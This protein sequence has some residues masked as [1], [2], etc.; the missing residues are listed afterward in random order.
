MFNAKT[1][2]TRAFKNI[3]NALKLL[4]EG[5]FKVTADRILLSEMDLTKTALVELELPDE[6]FDEFH[7][8]QD[9]SFRIDLDELRKVAKRITSND[10]IKLSFDDKSNQLLI[11]LENKVT[12]T[13]KIASQES[14]TVEL[15]TPQVQFKAEIKLLPELLTDAVK[16]VSLVSEFV[17]FLATEKLFLIQASNNT[18]GVKIEVPHNIDDVMEYN[19]KENCRAVYSVK[20]LKDML[21]VTSSAD[22]LTISFS[23]NMPLKLEYLLPGYAKVRYYLMAVKEELL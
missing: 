4:Y 18:A 13:F 21:A 2:D 23:S 1:W 14:D 7:C 17:E 8:D 16:D 19:V 20:Y 11:K 15:R 12:R 10:L 22:L 3:V 5:T 6:S 9:I